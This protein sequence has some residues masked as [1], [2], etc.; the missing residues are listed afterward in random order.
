MG[1]EDYIFYIFPAFITCIIIKLC[2]DWYLDNG[3]STIPEEY[4][5]G[6]KVSKMAPPYPGKKLEVK[7]HKSKFG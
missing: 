3:E 1:V 4:L 7:L 5:D 2:I 6:T